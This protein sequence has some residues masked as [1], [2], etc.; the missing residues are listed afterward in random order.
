[1]SDWWLYIISY[2]LELYGAL[3]VRVVYVCGVRACGVSS[4]P[5]GE[6]HTLYYSQSLLHG[7]AWPG[8]LYRI[9]EPDLRL[10]GHTNTFKGTDQRHNN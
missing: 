9:K 5:K 7:G 8:T 3:C 6:V 2:S 10:W 1:M 4:E